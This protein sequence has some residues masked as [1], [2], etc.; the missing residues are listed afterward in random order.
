MPPAAVASLPFSAEGPFTWLFESSPHCLALLDMDGRVIA[1]NQVCQRSLEREPLGGERKFWALSWPDSVRDELAVALAAACSGGSG[2]FDAQRR[3]AAGQLRWWNVTVTPLRDGA[4]VPVALL[5]ISRDITGQRNVE[6]RL[7]LLDAIGQATRA[8]SDALAIMEITTRLLGQYLG[9]TRC[10]YADLEDDNDIFTIR[11]DWTA[12]G[13]ASTAGVYSLDL[14][15]PRAAAELRGGGVLVIHDVRRELSAETGAAMF[16]AIGIEAIICCGLVKDGRLVAMMAVHQA[17]P[18]RWSPEEVALAQEVV[19][20]C[21]AHIERVRAMQTLR[22]E[23]RRKTEFLATL[24]HEL[25]NPLATIANGL[26]LLPLKM[27]DADGTTRVHGMMERQLSHLVHLVDDL[28]D[29]GRITQGKVALKRERVRLGAIV[30]SALEAARPLAET[31][32]HQLIVNQ[33]YAP[34]EL[35][36][37]ATRIA[38]VL[39]NLLNNAAKYTPEGGRIGLDVSAENGQAVVRVSDNGIGISREDLPSIFDL[40]MQAGSTREHAQGGMGIGLALARQLVQ[41]HG[42]SVHAASGGPGQGSCFTVRL[43]LAPALPQAAPQAASDAIP[44]AAPGSILVVDDNGDAAH[45]LADILELSGHAARVALSGPD[46]LDMMKREPAQIVLLDI[47]MPGM[48]GYEVARRLRAMHWQRRPVLV[49]LTG[50]GTE[51]DQSLTREAGFDHHLTKPAN[52]A[53]LNQI[54]SASLAV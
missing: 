15:G 25:R 44:E 23:D 12:P 10:A 9:A 53:A 46:A 47:G 39:G 52:L 34:L 48:D 38:Q 19:E 28:L 5:G 2:Q 7:R 1:L 22:Q 43:P 11:N 17:T 16:N 41:L 31:R 37:D 50:W 20:R 18:R 45:M 3:N 29:I 13:V 35:E 33:P 49:A 36:A 21:W 51:R 4:G 40:F 30:D 32:R 54:I 24:A 42:G 6:E 8:S 27:G 26:A 14:F